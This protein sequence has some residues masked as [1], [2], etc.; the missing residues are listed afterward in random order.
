V[1]FF[2]QPFCVLPQRLS[3]LLRCH[4]GHHNNTSSPTVAFLIIS[5][6]P[7]LST[8]HQFSTMSINIGINGFGRIGR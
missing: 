1:T 7:R 4:I 6:T 8:I 3:P 5:S 2:S